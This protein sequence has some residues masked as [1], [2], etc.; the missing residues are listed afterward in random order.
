MGPRGQKG[1]QGHSGPKGQL[2][3][4]GP[5]VRINSLIFG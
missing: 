1:D 2:G 3:A 4:R 5:P